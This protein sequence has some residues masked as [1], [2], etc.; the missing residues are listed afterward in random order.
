MVKKFLILEWKSFTRSASFA[1]N[2]AIKI[3][4]IFGAVYFAVVFVA[5]GSSAYYLIK[6]NGYPNPLLIVN[7]YV[8]YWFF[9][10]LFV[11]YMMQ[12]IPVMNIRPLMVLPIKKSTLVHFILGKTSIS[13]FNILHA[14]FFIPFSIVLLLNG[15]DVLGVITWHLGMMALV[16]ASNFLNVLANK[17]DK[18]LLLAAAVVIGL[19]ASQYFKVFDIT[20][21]TQVFFDALYETK[22]MVVVP[23]LVLAGLYFFAYRYFINNMYFDEKIV[24]KQETVSA[25]EYAWLNKYGTL[26][27]FLKNDIKLITRNKR[28]KKTVLAAFFFL[29]YGLL[30]LR[31]D[32][33][34]AGNVMQIFAGIFVSGGFL[35][36]FGQFVPSWDSGHYKLL[37]SQN[38]T[39]KDY[40]TSKWWLMVIAT[41]IS[42]VLASFYLYFGWETYMAIVVGAIYNIGVNSHLVLWGGAYVKTPIDLNAA[43][44]SFGNKQGFN[45]QTMLLSIPKLLVPIGLFAFGDYLFAPIAGFALVSLA[46][47][48]GFAFRNKVFAIIAKTYKT[49]KYKTIAAYAQNNA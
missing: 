19:I 1:A 16:F 18:I 5:L 11:R 39:Y 25:K 35:L 12:T 37:M 10:H 29:F 31:Q 22:I 33:P 48:L 13:F 17:Q 4:M 8:F 23:I 45:V 46:G 24:A 34:H 27:A 30:F 40:L 2:L 44:N 38:I 9:G 36:N 42:T 15:Y 14:F 6:E 20:S 32:M 49:E 47:I 43:N 3:L 7:K 41:V 26:G 28:S 21:Y